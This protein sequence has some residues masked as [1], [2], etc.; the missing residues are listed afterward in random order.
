MLSAYIR[1]N[2]LLLLL[3]GVLLGAGLWL[4]MLWLPYEVSVDLWLFNSSPGLT[5]LLTG[6]L[7]THYRRKRWLLIGIGSLL[8]LG[9]TLVVGLGNV[10][11]L[12]FSSASAPVTDVSQYEAVRSHYEDLISVSHFPAVIPAEATNV[13]FYHAPGALQ[14]SMSM[15]LRMEL[16]SEM[17]K[18]LKSEYEAVAQY[19]F[20]AA[21]VTSFSEENQV[22]LPPIASF[23][24]SDTE[25]QFP[26]AYE[27]LVLDFQDNDDLD[28]VISYGVALNANPPEIVYWMW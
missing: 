18:G 11:G 28:R 20:S 7:A 14:G 9:I 24:T 13:K 16:P 22:P 2:P 3:S 19:Q 8:T 4:N 21:D 5:L 27:I 17:W 6:F 10:V 26:D 15:Q 1:H 25:S 23:S 12:A